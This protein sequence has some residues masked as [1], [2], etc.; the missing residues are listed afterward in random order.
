MAGDFIT[1]TWLR[2]HFGLAH[3]TEVQLPAGA[4]LTPSARQLLDERRI[5]LR[6][7]DEQGRTFQPGPDGELNRV[8]PLT[9]GN[10]RPGNHCSVCGGDV[11]V[12]P[13]LLTHLDDQT[14]VVKTHPR[15][16]LRGRLDSLVADCIV[17]QHQL[18]G[19]ARYPV[20]A[21]YLSDLRSFLGNVLRAEVTGEPLGDIAMGE[22]DAATLH[23]LS[24]EPLKY[25]H[26]DH[27]V[28]AA[29]HGPDVA[30][31]N[32]LRARVREV[33]LLATHVYLDDELQLSRPDIV[34]GLN[35]LSSAIYVLMLLL[36]V[37]A[38]GRTEL[39]EGS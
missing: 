39:L 13:S 12:K 11:A 7:L 34:T 10:R 16:A 17:L 38:Q 28:P 5:G 32:Q 24:H 29:E 15:I 27:I 35:R 23:R 3:G 22:M 36:L 4:R 19:V 31:L 8:H 2:Q 6:Y 9:T 18:P 33:E 26:H 14:L 37:A 25:L 1:E 21:G 20:A 30:M